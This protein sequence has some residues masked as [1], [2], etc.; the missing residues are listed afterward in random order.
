MMPIFVTGGAGYIGSVVT[1]QLVEQSHAVLCS[2]TCRGPHRDAVVDGAEFVQANLHNYPKVVRALRN[3]RRRCS[4]P[5]RRRARG[6][7]DDQSGG[8]AT[9]T[10]SLPA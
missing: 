10:A 2:T 5:P 7:I 4:C 8:M 1:E 9:R 3:L 6:R